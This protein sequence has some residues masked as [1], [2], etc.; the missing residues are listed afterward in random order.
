M[1]KIKKVQDCIPLFIF[2]LTAKINLV[3]GFII[4][5][6]EFIKEVLSIQYIVS[7]F[8]SGVIFFT[9]CQYKLCYIAYSI[10]FI[11]MIV[12]LLGIGLTY[13]NIDTMP[14]SKFNMFSFLRTL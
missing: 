3:S 6:Y 1:N 5:G 2:L 11:Y 4:Y 10:S 9:L 13:Q 7:I 12:S 8:I 14:M